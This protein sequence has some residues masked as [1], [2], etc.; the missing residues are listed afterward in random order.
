MEGITGNPSY[1]DPLFAFLDETAELFPGV[2]ASHMRRLRFLKRNQQGVSKAVMVKA[3]QRGQESLQGLAVSCLKG[4]VQGGNSLVN[5]FHG[6]F[7]F[8]GRCL[9]SMCSRHLPVG[10]ACWPA[11]GQDRQRDTAS[12]GGVLA[13]GQAAA[14]AQGGSGP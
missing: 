6:V 1:R 10:V 8:H 12:Q 14:D 4:C 9:L 13:A 3:G 5:Q 11:G 7:S 2:K